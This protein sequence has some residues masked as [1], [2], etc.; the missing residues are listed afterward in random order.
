MALLEPGA[1]YTLTEGHKALI[2]ALEHLGFS[3]EDEVTFPPYTV[4]CYIE[5]VHMAFEFDG[6]QHSHKRDEKR[7]T[8]L[9]ARYALP[10]IRVTE[11]SKDPV[12]V[13][14]QIAAE[15]IDLWKS[16]SNNRRGFADIGKYRQQ[17]E[18]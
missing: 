15:L 2:Y 1:K 12:T 7:D 13:I 17:A 16:S 3:V 4:D 8:I 9:M 6:P 14:S 18:G 5:N 11:F 10:V